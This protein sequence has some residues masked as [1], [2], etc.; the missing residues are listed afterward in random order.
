VGRAW[1]G[2]TGMIPYYSGFPSR[3]PDR[4]NLPLAITRSFPADIQSR[5]HPLLVDGTVRLVAMTGTEVRAEVSGDA[6][7]TVQLLATR[8]RITA[9]CTCTT[10]AERGACPHLFAVLTLAAIRRKLVT[11][12]DTAGSGFTL[13]LASRAAPLDASLD[14]P[15]DGVPTEQPLATSTGIASSLTASTLTAPTDA[16]SDAAPR[17]ADASAGDAD[18]P[19]APGWSSA[20]ARM[21]VE[22]MVAAGQEGPRVSTL[23]ADRR[24]VY[25]VDLDQRL[26]ADGLLVEIGTE[27]RDRDGNW[28]DPRRFHFASSAWFTAANAVDRQVAE[29]LVGANDT[30]G[31]TGMP[32]HGFAVRPRAFGT[33][34]R[35][36]CDTERC[37][38]LSRDAARD[39]R[40]LRWDDGAA[41][42][43]QFRIEP[44][45]IA[46]HTLRATLHRDDRMLS[47]E[48]VT[49]VHPAGLLL[50]D[51]TLARVDWQGS[52][53]LVQQLQDEPLALGDQLN[54]FLTQWNALTDAPTLVV[55]AEEPLAS[56]DT[57]PVPVL[58]I[59]L[60]EHGVRNAPATLA[61][62]FRYGTVLVPP[63]LRG[64][65]SYDTS[66]R[67]LHRRDAAFERRCRARLLQLG[68][69]EHWQGTQSGD[70]FTLLR[71][72]VAAL[73]AAL[74]GTSTMSG[75][76]AATGANAAAGNGA[77]GNGAVAGDVWEVTLAGR[78]LHVASAPLLRVSTDIDWFDLEGTVPFGPH[79]LSLAQLLAL[80]PGAHDGLIALPGGDWGLV[81]MDDVARLSRLLAMGVTREGRVR[82]PR[83]Q[84][85]LLDALLAALPH[86][87]VDE[88]L[89]EARARL[90]RFNGID[91]P[92]A[93]PGFQGTLRGYQREGLGWFG[94]LRDFG[95][96]GCL[97]DDMGLGKTIQV[98][99]LLEERRVQGHG[100]S[101]LVVPRSLVFNWQREA[102]RFV[103]SLRVHDL[104]GSDRD[105]GRLARE[106][107]DVFITTYGTLR[108]DVEE[109]G[110][111]EFD[112]VVLDEAQ[113]IKNA[114]TATA[115]ASRLLRARHRLAL[116]GTPVE[117]RL[118]ELWS[119]FEFLNPGM[120]GASA[121]LATADAALL[122]RA[123]RPVILRR[124]KAAVASE[125]PARVEQTLEVT[126]EPRQR[127]FYEQLRR[128]YAESVLAQVDREGMHKSRMHILE[129]L[130]RLRQA[131]CHPV[132]VDPTRGGTPSA[133]LDA[134]VPALQEIAS[135]GYKAL[136][137]SQFTSFLSQLRHRLDVLGVPYEYLD[138][139]TRDRQARVDRFQ[140][141]D[142]P[143]VFLISL[144]AGGHGLNLTAAEY[145]Y[146]LDPWWNP[147]VEAQAIDRAHRIGQERQVFATRVV[148]RDTIESKILELQAGKRALADAILNEDRGGLSGIGRAE[149]ELLLG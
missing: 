143:P 33:T 65:S 71:G 36:I 122:S 12:L 53:P 149:L 39:G 38:T 145:V 79:E 141:A 28:G 57:P 47:L 69:Q 75:P 4:V 80:D 146:L 76:A 55:P 49:W 123:L 45:A 8:G 64:T 17:G 3:F 126:L 1:L 27:R 103:P 105:V 119:L 20:L 13:D 108:V 61:L 86:V 60:D 107:A 67:T 51:D 120:L 29:M 128:R 19:A 136:V 18:M 89:A 34:L 134:V 99:A 35:L 26:R 113:A 84:L 94:F 129:A 46:R 9:T 32:A 137:F 85:L 7:C 15:A 66:T 14:A 87:D 96:G 68:A 138:G 114:G 63:S 48:R 43:V 81:S 41:W 135:E 133:K 24:I 73:V 88:Q 93:P 6:P 97:A 148:A 124:T 74:S 5:A 50:L 91:T 109:L 132:L 52:F 83:T 147:A 90:A 42:R 110:A 44:D 22:R 106:D 11:L 23:P 104:S 102:E 92:D 139:R 25:L 56:V 10:A 82:F 70:A 125:L 62:R 112:Y 54:A 121:R 59:D 115:K 140:S 30:H 37:R 21:A 142:G 131:A 2:Q 31:L 117:N 116:S 130:L 16:G 78:A 72:R 144:K 101:L 95:L 100:P 127:T 58:T 118:E 77:S 40:T 98:L 111:H